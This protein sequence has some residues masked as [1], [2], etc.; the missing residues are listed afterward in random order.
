MEEPVKKRSEA[1]QCLLALLLLIL[2]QLT[3]D[4]GLDDTDGDGLAHITDGEATERGVLLVRLDA[5]GLGGDD[6]ADSGITTLDGLRV[7]LDLLAG[8]LVELLEEL[9]ELA[10]NVG[11]VAIEDGGVTSTE[12]VG[13]VQDD[14]LGSE[15]GD[16]GGGVVLGVTSN[17]TTLDILDGEGLDGETDVVTGL[18]GLKLLVVHF[19]G[20]DLRG[21]AD[22][23]EGD[24]HA[25]LQETG[26]DTADGD[27]TDTTDLVHILQGQ[28]QRLVDRA[29]GGDDVV[30]SLNHGGALV[31]L[32]L[33]GTLDHVITV[34]AG[35]GDEGDE[36]LLV[37]VLEL[38]T[39]LGEV[40][41]QL[42]LDFGVTGLAVV[43][44]LVIH[45]VD[46]DNHLLDTEGESEQS[47]LL[48]LTV[49]TIT[50]LELTLSTSNHQDGA[51][52][53]RGTGNHVLDEVTVAR[54]I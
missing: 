26:L 40:L 30:Q 43:D 48:G 19:D 3:A 29:L 36:L 23:G 31:P 42:V 28:T 2:G 51:V 24:G 1:P 13:V 9:V 50:G 44:G 33:V 14:N 34:P 5:H 15:V 49:G 32:H 20:L 39:A 22:G 37:L 27:R 11:G 53:L 46:A 38:V 6:L 8:T 7:V 12:T 16:T 52:S 45:L 10:G 35:D 25:G 54:G 21:L 18:S 47:V 41:L 4:G 17:V